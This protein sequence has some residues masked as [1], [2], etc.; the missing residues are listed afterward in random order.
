MKDTCMII[1][2]LLCWNMYVPIFVLIFLCI[3]VWDT[4]AE[5]T[6]S[7]FPREASGS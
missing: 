2:S 1:L 4:Y 6:G 3:M 5:P 7:Q